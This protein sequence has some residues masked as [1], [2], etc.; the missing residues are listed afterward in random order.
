[1]VKLAAVAIVGKTGSSLSNSLTNWAKFK[2]FL[3]ALT[4]K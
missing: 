1:M 2:V 4:S 3:R